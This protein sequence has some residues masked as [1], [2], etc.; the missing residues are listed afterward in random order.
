MIEQ[1][2]KYAELIVRVGVNLQ[3]GQPL[4]IGFGSRQV[5]PD[6]VPFARLLAEAAYDAGASYVHIDWGDEWW[7]RETVKCADIGI[8]RE[9]AKWQVA[10][11]ERL[12]EMGAAY[13]AMPASD[14]ALFA[15][16]PR[17]R[18]EQAERAV[19]EAFRPFDNERTND[20]HRWTLASAPTQAWADAVHPELAREE[21]FE[22]LWRDILQAS[23]ATG[24]DPIADWE[25]HIANLKRRAA[26]LNG[27]K[28]R[29]LH[30]RAPGTDLTIE[31]AEGH[32]FEAAGHPD[33]KGIRFVAN[34]PTE[35]V[36]TA[37]KK[38]GV[39]GTVA[40]TMPL[41]HGGSLIEGIRLRFENGRI[42]EYSAEKGEEALKAIIEADEGSHYLGEVALVPVDSPIA[43]MNRIFYNTLFDENASCHLAIGRAYPLVEGGHQLAHE[44]WEARGLNDSLMHVDFM[45][46]SPD[47]D[48][49]ALLQDGRTVP[50]FRGGR[51]VSEA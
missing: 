23:R 41:N 18:V 25:H 38:T 13:I 48:I 2:R 36:F 5:Y 33:V 28:I 30:Y 15:G 11:V 42:V 6:Q 8:L 24:E 27:L 21:R 39:N 43:Q 20:K 35:E 1:L 16:I 51:W 22:A 37:P 45:I 17:D 7:L 10:W 32:Y 44:E 47:L 29:A 9:R 12:A 46:G 26:W 50:I 14:P 3:P 31:L 4:V 34:I 49:D 40:S 19:R